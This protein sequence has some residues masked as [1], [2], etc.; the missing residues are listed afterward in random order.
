MEY[1]L[2]ERQEAFLDE[3]EAMVRREKLADFVN[4]PRLYFRRMRGGYYDEQILY[5]L[6]WLSAQSE[7]DDTEY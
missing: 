3:A 6:R 5:R 1:E 4:S 7:K 2:N